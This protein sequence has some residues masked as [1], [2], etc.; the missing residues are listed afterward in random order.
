M[1][2]MNTILV[3]LVITLVSGSCRMVETLTGNGKA[4]TVSNLWSDVPPVLGA[5]RTDLALPL[6]ARLMIRAAMQGKVSFIAFSTEKSAQEVQDFYNKARM[7]SAGWTASEQGCVGDTEDQKSQ[8]A[9]CMFNHQDGKKK[10]GLAIVLAHDEKS[11]QTD[12]FYARIDLTES[13]ASPSP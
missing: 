7:K 12:I 1:R 6:G 2:T 10:E 4:G 11:K 5:T 13:E 3:C 9:V 8:G